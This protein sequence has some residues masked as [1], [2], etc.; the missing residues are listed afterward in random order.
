MSTAVEILTN[1]IVLPPMKLDPALAP[2]SSP[3]M[4]V[5]TTAVLRF[6]LAADI[7]AQAEALD[8]LVRICRKVTKGWGNKSWSTRS[9]FLT[10]P[11][12]HEHWDKKEKRW[13]PEPRDQASVEWIGEWLGQQLARYTGLSV[14]DIE[15]AAQRGEFADLAIRCR[16]ALG[17]EVQRRKKKAVVEEVPLD[18]MP[19]EH[20]EREGAGLLQSLHVEAQPTRTHCQSS[21]AQRVSL[22]ERVQC[23]QRILDLTMTHAPELK[24]LDLLDGLLCVAHAIRLEPCGWR[25]FSAEFTRLVGKVRHVGPSAALAYKRKFERTMNAECEKGNKVVQ[26]VMLEL[27][28]ETKSP[29][30]RMM[31]LPKEV[32]ERERAMREAAELNSKFYQDLYAAG[33]DYKEPE[34]SR[35]VN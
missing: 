31:L 1:P 22:E 7:V 21:L 29:R 3:T 8:E 5:M 26:A 25:A 14:A 6:L 17:R 9:L 33:I 35:L 4:D 10:E 16:N 24:E 19:D 11:T 15:A 30:P 2:Q 28:R 18:P 27:V 34:I 13:I 23:A 20:A 32:R 12:R